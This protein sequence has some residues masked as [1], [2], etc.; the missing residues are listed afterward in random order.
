[1]TMIMIDKA[2]VE[3]ALAALV[4]SEVMHGQPN[5]DIQDKLREALAQ[6]TTLNGNDIFQDT[7]GTIPVTAV[8]QQVG[9]VAA[10]TAATADKLEQIEAAVKEL[11]ETLEDLADYAGAFSVSG[12][13]LVED[14]H[15]RALLA[16]AYKLVLKY[17]N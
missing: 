2:V 1:M 4:R 11:T 10:A 12:V 9:F 15:A 17:D 8:G 13:Y 16:Q 7:E 6:P 3:Q 5:F 14:K